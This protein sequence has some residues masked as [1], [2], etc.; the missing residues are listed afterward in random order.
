MH[1]TWVL[2]SEQGTTRKAHAIVA[3][4]E[5]HVCCALASLT[6]LMKTQPVEMAQLMSAQ[7]VARGCSRSAV[8]CSSVVGRTLP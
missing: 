4:K 8:L 6:T 5:E 7:S 2:V 3:N 1:D